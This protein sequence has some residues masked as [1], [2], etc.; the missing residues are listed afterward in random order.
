[1]K[2]DYKGWSNEETFRVV[3]YFNLNTLKIR[4][5][6]QAVELSL[7]RRRSNKHSKVKK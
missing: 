7:L 2:V 3:S 6:I 5:G 1:M 4:D